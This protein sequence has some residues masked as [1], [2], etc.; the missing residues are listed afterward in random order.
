MC[1]AN[2]SRL[3]SEGVSD[4]VVCSRGGVVAHD[5]VMAVRVLHLVDGEWFGKGK[6]APVRKTAD[7]TAV[8]EDQT[9]HGVCNSIKKSLLEDSFAGKEGGLVSRVGFNV[10]SDFRQVARSDLCE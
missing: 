10:L 1:C 5:K 6:D 2:H 3:E 7:D 4:V 9:S 8:A